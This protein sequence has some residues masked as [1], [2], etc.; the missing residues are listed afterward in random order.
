M[1]ASYYVYYRVSPSSHAAARQAVA[2][3]FLNLRKSLGI[4]GRLARRRDDPHTWMEI[5]EGVGDTQ[6]FGDALEQAA[7]E[8]A[9]DACLQTGAVRMIEIFVP[10]HVDGATAQQHV[11]DE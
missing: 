9:I 2:A 11:A 1:S 7:R 10:M 3:L 4:V 6:I 8:C 5:Y